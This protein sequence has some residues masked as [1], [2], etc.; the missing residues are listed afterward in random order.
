MEL[1][2]RTVLAGGFAAMLGSTVV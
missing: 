2:R 1:S